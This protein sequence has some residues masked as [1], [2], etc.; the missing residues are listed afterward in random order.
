[1]SEEEYMTL[2][3]ER[4]ASIKKLQDEKSFYEYE[5]QFSELWTGLGKEVMEK[6][7]SE[8]PGNVQKKTLSEPV[9]E[10]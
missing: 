2:A 7:I 4:Y 1:M 5:K 8:V 10:K 6:S 3:R 9:S